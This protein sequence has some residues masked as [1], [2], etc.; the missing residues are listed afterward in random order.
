MLV[1]L[2]NREQMH[3]NPLLFN[4]GFSVFRPRIPRH[5]SLLRFPELVFTDNGIKDLNISW[6]VYI[7]G[8]DTVSW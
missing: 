4:G 1:Y 8:K 2:S 7:R 5:S 3:S 6:I